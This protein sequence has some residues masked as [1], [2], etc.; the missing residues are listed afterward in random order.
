MDFAYLDMPKDDFWGG[1]YT[2]MVKDVPP[3]EF[4]IFN[5]FIDSAPDH[6]FEIFNIPPYLI[7]NAAND[8]GFEQTVYKK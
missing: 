3:K 1:M 7:F 5:F 2:K 6:P 4:E 8:A